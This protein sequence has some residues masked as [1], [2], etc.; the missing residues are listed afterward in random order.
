MSLSPRPITQE[1]S[2]FTIG[3]VGHR[4]LSAQD[5]RLSRQIISAIKRLIAEHPGREVLLISSV[6]EGA[7]RLCLTASRLLGIPYVC[8]LPCP[9][10]CFREDFSSAR[11]R[12]EFDQLLEAAEFVIQPEVELDKE[13]GYFW[14]SEFILDRADVIVAVWNGEPGNGIGGTGD[15]VA[16]A[17]ERG[18][19]VTWIFSEPPHSWQAIDHSSQSPS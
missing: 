14:A 6:A 11:S 3:A 5:K 13:L 18:I 15:T 9:P 2:Q 19:P 7:D 16:R 8:V 17:L 1:E 10:D 4:R 12:S